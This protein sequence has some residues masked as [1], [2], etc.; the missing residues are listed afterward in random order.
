MTVYGYAKVKPNA[1]A[2]NLEALVWFLRWHGCTTVITD[3][4]YNTQIG[5]GWRELVQKLRPGDLVRVASLDQVGNSTKVV[6][7][8]V[9]A[10]LSR[11][12]RLEAIKD[13]APFARAC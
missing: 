9:D 1:P 8:A 2:G 11:R 13:S 12:A 3:V 4:G 7:E 10:L 5:H 6:G